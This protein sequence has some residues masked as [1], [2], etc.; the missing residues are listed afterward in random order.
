[1]SR[2]TPLYD[3]MTILTDGVTSPTPLPVVLVPP[4]PSFVAE[5][6]AVKRHEVL[7]NPPEEVCITCFDLSTKLITQLRRQP[8]ALSF[9]PLNPV[10]RVLAIYVSKSVLTLRSRAKH[11]SPP[12]CSAAN[13][14]FNKDIHILLFNVLSHVEAR[15]QVVLA[16]PLRVPLDQLAE[17]LNKDAVRKELVCEHTSLQPNRIHP[18]VLEC[19]HQG[20]TSAA[21]VARRRRSEV[22]HENHSHLQTRESSLF[23][24]AVPLVPLVVG[25]GDFFRIGLLSPP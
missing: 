17:I 9:Q 11:K 2:M 20:A 1:V 6:N 15:H 24:H 12:R 10:G 13:K 22:L 3:G 19:S 5:T 8:K 7:T 21:N 18:T 25:S 23:A 16:G 4:H 14:V